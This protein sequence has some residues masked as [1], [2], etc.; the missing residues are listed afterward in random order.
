LWSA[1][2]WPL[3]LWDEQTNAAVVKDLVTK[4]DLFP[5]LTLNG[6]A[7]F[8]KPPL[9]YYL[10]G[11]IVRTAGYSAL[12]LRM[13][14]V[15][16][17]IASMVVIFYLLYRYT[18]K[19]KA[20]L[21][22]VLISAVNQLFVIN[23]AGYFSSHTLW[24]AD[25]DSLQ[26]LLLLLAQ[27]FFLR[28]YA[29]YRKR[30]LYWSFI[31]LGL[32]ILT[33][34][35]LA[36][37]ALIFQSWY[38]LKKRREGFYGIKDIIGCI[39]VFLLLALPWHIAMIVNYG[40]SFIDI[41][42]NYHILQRTLV[43]IEAHQQHWSFYLVLLIDPRINM[44]WPVLYY[45]IYKSFKSRNWSLLIKYNLFCV[46]VYYILINL[47]ATKLAWYMLYFWVIIVLI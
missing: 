47:M 46:L 4:Q 11:L 16:S 34:G 36:L 25:L 15:L 6:A 31:F 9:W 35:P 17:A 41:Y 7:F 40:Q 44:L 43:G 27:L 12:N 13:V 32:S 39:F 14:S 42:F 22:L 30:W 29:L 18:T 24:T 10:T 19:L 26:I 2:S 23:A 21:V 8:E 37:I 1:G 38:L 20:L 3:E 28:A 33:K 45:K 5:S